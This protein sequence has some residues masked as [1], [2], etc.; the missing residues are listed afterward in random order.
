[1]IVFHT[2]AFVIDPTEQEL[3]EPQEQAPAEA[4]NPEQEQ[5]NPSASN[6]YPWVLFI[7]I[8]YLWF[9]DVQ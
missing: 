6:H 1:M 7:F 2:C 4:S 3:E 8:S 5:G 9:L